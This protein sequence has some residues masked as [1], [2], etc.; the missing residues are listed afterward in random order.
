VQVFNMTSVVGVLD[1]VKAKAVHVGIL[2]KDQ[3]D[4]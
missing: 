2:V 3:H 1:W 4:V